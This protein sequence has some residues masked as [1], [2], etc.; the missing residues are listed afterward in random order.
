VLK[1]SPALH[2]QIDNAKADVLQDFQELSNLAR[3]RDIYPALIGIAVS[4]SGYVC[5]LVG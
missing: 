3:L 1:L 2:E 5:Q 4:I